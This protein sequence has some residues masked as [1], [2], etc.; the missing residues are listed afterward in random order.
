LI[1][2]AETGAESAAQRQAAAKPASAKRDDVIARTSLSEGSRNLNQSIL[3]W[4]GYQG[5]KQAAYLN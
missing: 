2:W 1:S 4:Y 3:P 5:L